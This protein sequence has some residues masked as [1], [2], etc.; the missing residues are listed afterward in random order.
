MFSTA[1]VNVLMNLIWRFMSKT[2]EQITSCG[3]LG[4]NSHQTS[5]NPATGFVLTHCDPLWH[6]ES[7][8]VGAKPLHKPMLTYHHLNLLEQTDEILIKLHTFSF[9]KM[10]LKMLSTKCWP[11]R[12]G[13]IVLT[14]LGLNSLIARFYSDAC[15]SDPR[16]I[17]S[18]KIHLPEQLHR[19]HPW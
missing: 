17:C 19:N 2:P 15:L 7:M 3:S 12:S 14:L 16:H 9:R 11:F 10:F 4:L 8:S 18:N 1:G 6:H 13:L 5:Q